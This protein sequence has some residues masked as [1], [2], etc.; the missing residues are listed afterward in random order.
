MRITRGKVVG[1]QIVIEGEPLSEGSTVTVLV[2][3]ERTFTLSDQ[4]EAALLD[5]IAEADKGD[6]LDAYD[7]LGRLPWR[8]LMLPIKITPRA[9]EQMQKAASWW[10]ANREAAPDALKEELRLAFDFISRH[11]GVGTLAT[12]TRLKGVRRIYLSR[13]RYHLYY[14]VNLSS[15]EIEILALWHASRGKG[16][17]I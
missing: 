13:V 4:D 1:G 15:S 8:P 11:P 9:E 5:S 3:D 12:N 10:L 6:L 17:S 14:R 16:P 7:V 2:S